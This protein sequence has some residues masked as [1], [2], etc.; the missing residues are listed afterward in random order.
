MIAHLSGKLLLKG[1]TSVVIDVG[2]VGYE[3]T[4]PLSTAY[5]LG[6]TGSDVSLRIYTHVREDALQLYGFK[7]GRERELFTLLISVSGIGA[8]SA[9]A[10]LSAMSADEIAGA[11]R[12]NN[13]ARLTGIPGI[14]RKT[15]ERLVI[16]LR[17]KILQ[18]SSPALEEAIAAGNGKAAKPSLDTVYDDALEALISLGYAKP[19]AEKALK[20][21][22]T[23]GGEIS[24]QALL[25]RSLRNLSK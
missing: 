7:S 21:A 8:K 16:E 20:T 3:V 9:I 13:L 15:A 11:I 23:D 18:I 10:M 6:E 12:T 22:M 19:V 14:G 25:R 2:G 4:I 17:D 1:A 24:V 5:E